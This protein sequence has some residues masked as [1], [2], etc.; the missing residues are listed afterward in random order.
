MRVLAVVGQFQVERQVVADLRSEGHLVVSAQIGEDALEY[1]RRYEFDVVVLS[2][3]PPIAQGLGQVW[4]MRAVRADVPMLV[5]ASTADADARTAMLEAGVDDVMALPPDRTELDARL[6]A[7][8]RRSRGHSQQT[9]TMG[10][11]SFSLKTRRA[12]VNGNALSLTAKESSVLEL[13]MLRCD[14]PLSKATFLDQLY[15]DAEHEPDPRI[16]DVFVCKLRRKLAD[17]GVPDL[18]GTVWGQGYIVR[19][20]ARQRQDRVQP[21]EVPAAFT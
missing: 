12:T 10:G 14:T 20:A 21:G 7:L 8:L 4:R 3:R 15:P 9:L 6:Q 18:I 17:A 11:V 16:I 2:L 5:V 13:L 19:S 1:A